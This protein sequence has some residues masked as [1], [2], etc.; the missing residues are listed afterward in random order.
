MKIVKID[1]FL[2]LFPDKLKIF[3]CQSFIIILCEFEMQQQFTTQE[4][5]NLFLNEN[6]KDNLL[7]WINE[8]DT[9]IELCGFIIAVPILFTWIID[10]GIVG[11]NIFEI[12]TIRPDGT[13]GTRDEFYLDFR[14]GVLQNPEVLNQANYY[15]HY[16]AF[17]RSYFYEGNHME[18]NRM[19][20]HWGS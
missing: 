20:L 1:Y 16:T 18:E 6:N 14:E 13:K 3:P 4:L 19:Y 9:S 7:K 5:K 8:T 15:R 11:H 17:N 12:E 10:T 2:F